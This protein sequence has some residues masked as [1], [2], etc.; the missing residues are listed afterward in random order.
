MVSVTMALRGL[1]AN[2]LRSFLTML[3]V[4]IGVA[5]VIVAI[6]IGQGARE[7]SLENLRK[8]G[9]NVLTVMPG[10][11][12]RGQISFGFGSIKT[13]KLEDAE[14]IK[15]GCPSILRVSPGVSRRGIQV[16]YKNKNT[17]TAINGTGEDYLTISNNVL[18]EG[19]YFTRG[20]VQGFKR[21]AVLGYTVHRDLFDRESPVGKKIRIGGTSFDVIGRL[22][23]KGGQGW[24]NPDDAVYV[25]VTTCMRR[26]SSGGGAP[27]SSST[28]GSS[29][30]STTTV[31]RQDYLS[32]ITCQA[33][34]EFVM[35]RAIDEINAVMRR[36]HEVTGNKEPDWLIFN[37]ADAVE[38]QDEQQTVFSSLITYLAIVSLIVGGIGIMNIMLVSVTERTREI[39]IRKAIGAKRRN[40]LSQFL[41]EAVFLSV[42]GGLIGVWLG[43]WLAGVVAESN[44]WTVI[45]AP[46][47]VAIAFSFSAIV[48]VFFGFYPALKA[49]KLNPI[50]ALRYE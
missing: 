12:R 23:E 46:E 44:E 7:A 6:G 26:V 31:S 29:T 3:G 40:V 18:V 10:Q 27:S 13:L 41:M 48:G 43:I 45:V 34:N 9:T 28:S 38:T 22:K 16:K 4:I 30:T 20:E 11:E 36:Q 37:Q 8:L 2:K 1:S 32:N 25:P 14:A 49:S 50:E 17:N 19:R 33:R 35:E 39:G 21:V 15:R 24:M 47:T 42:T 5:A